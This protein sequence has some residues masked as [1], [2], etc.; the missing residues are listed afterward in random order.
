MPVL[1]KSNNVGTE[2][3]KQLR[4]RKLLNGH[5]FMIN[6]RELPANHCYLEFPDGSIK[7]VTVLDSQRDFTIIKELSTAESQT[8]RHKFHLA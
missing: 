1:E 8:I 6:S 7:L 5:P 3:V 2:A 4:L